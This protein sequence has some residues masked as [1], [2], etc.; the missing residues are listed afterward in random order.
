MTDSSD[1]MHTFLMRTCLVL[2]RFSCFW[3]CDPMGH[4]LPCSAIHW[5]LQARILEWVAV[6]SS[7][8]SSWP[9]DR[10]YHSCIWAS[11]LAGRLFT[12]STTWEALFLEHWV[13]TRITCQGKLTRARFSSFIDE[14]SFHISTSSLSVL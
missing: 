14:N 12:T 11:A 7:R 13:P 1:R 5:I 2:S 9:G 6:P 4:S 8:G 10:T 3:L